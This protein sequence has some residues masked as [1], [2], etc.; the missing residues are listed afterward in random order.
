MTRDGPRGYP[1]IGYPAWISR[2]VLKPLVPRLWLF[3]RCGRMMAKRRTENHLLG[4]Q[5]SSHPNTAS[6]DPRPTRRNQDL[7]PSRPAGR[8]GMPANGLP[9]VP[10]PHPL[11][12]TGAGSGPFG[13]WSGRWSISCRAICLG[14][15]APLADGPSPSTLPS[16]CP[17]NAT[18]RRRSST[19]PGDSSKAAA[20]RT[21]RRCGWTGSGSSTRPTTAGRTCGN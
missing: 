10:L 11:L 8:R 21:G 7:Q 3:C 6:D 15:S 14:L 12:G 20:W 2:P 18:A 17:T 19:G 4:S 9:I 5:P 13:S 16:L 1:A